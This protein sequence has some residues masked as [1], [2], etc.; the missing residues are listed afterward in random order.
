MPLRR[1]AV[2]ALASALLACSTA[3]RAPA[4]AATSPD[5][6]AVLAE[7]DA[8]LGLAQFEVAGARYEEAARL[9]PKDPRP[10]LGLARVRLAAAQ[11]A[12][13]L[14]LLDRSI[15]LGATPEALILRGR[16]LGV[17]RRFDDA[18][19]DLERGLALAPGDG[20]AWPILA[21]IQV[22]RGDELAARRA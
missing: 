12:E 16:T 13:G 22:N 19:R 9:A 6:T 17:A 20:S 18:A 10:L 2:A 14:A 1:T 11:A 3:P 15:A 5:V 7:A 8:A 21:A 4:V